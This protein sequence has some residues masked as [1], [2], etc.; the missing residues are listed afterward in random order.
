MLIG[1]SLLYYRDR[2]ST[3]LPQVRVFFLK[4]MGS[5]HLLN[6]KRRVMFCFTTA[7]K[8]VTLFSDSWWHDN[9]FNTATASGALCNLVWFVRCP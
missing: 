4:L 7:H 6:V 1:F 2:D 9:L 5:W 8:F 3:G